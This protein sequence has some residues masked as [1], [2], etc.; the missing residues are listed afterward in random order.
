MSVLAID[1]GNS[2]LGI[3]VFTDGKSQDSA[4]R[5]TH[6]QID[7]ELPELLKQLH[8]KAITETQEAGDDETGVVMVSVVPELTAKVAKIIDAVLGV[9]VSVIGRD[10]KIPLKHKLRD[11]STVGQDRLAAALASYVN[12]ETA[13]VIV[14]V[15]SALVVDCIDEEGIFRGGAIAPGLAMGAHALHEFSAQLPEVSLTPPDESEPF[16]RY[17]EEAINLG[18]Y[19]SA[20][21]G[22]RELIERYATALGNWPHVVAT[23]GDAQALLGSSEFVDSFIPDLVLQGAALTWEHDRRAE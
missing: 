10:L 13:C 15:G 14:Q 18:L 22:V 7:A 4:V 21:G 19:M 20:R 23:G 6:A 11:E 3:G 5:I 17:T 12:V 2:R 9:E 16:G 8:Q 1:I